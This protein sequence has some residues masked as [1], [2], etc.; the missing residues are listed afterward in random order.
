M[1][2]YNQGQK[3]LLP[4]YDNKNFCCHIYAIF[5][6]IPALLYNKLFA[7]RTINNFAIL[8]MNVHTQNMIGRDM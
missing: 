4:K 5:N 8:K 6:T 2:Y 3:F 1:N 7:H